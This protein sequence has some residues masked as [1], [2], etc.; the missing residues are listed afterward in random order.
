MTVFRIVNAKRLNMLG[1]V[2]RNPSAV[3][4][5]LLA[6]DKA[7]VAAGTLK[8]GRGRL[9]Q[10]G[11]A[12]TE[13]EI[14]RT[15]TLSTGGR[16]GNIAGTSIAGPF[17]AIPAVGPLAGMAGKKIGETATRKTLN[18]AYVTHRNLFKK[19]RT[20]KDK[21]IRRTF[22][23]MNRLD[24]MKGKNLIAEATIPSIVKNAKKVHKGELAPRQFL[25]VSVNDIKERLYTKLNI[26][27][28]I[29]KGEARERWLN[30]KINKMIKTGKFRYQRAGI[31]SLNPAYSY[32]N[33]A[34]FRRA[35]SPKKIR[36]PKSSTAKNRPR[37]LSL[38]KGESAG[39]C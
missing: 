29:K 21:G 25:Q 26:E 35:S 11:D 3:A 18:A 16:V 17:I 30:G 9:G 27:K 13:S 33:I 19:R 31:I 28:R 32:S 5:T 37:L 34:A 2:A 24:R 20:R 10:L 1:T 23:A 22:G 8:T 6:A 38:P 14:A 15:L 4:K 7:A 39:F 36:H 12:V